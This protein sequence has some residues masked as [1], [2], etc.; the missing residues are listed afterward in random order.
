[1]AMPK[2]R[3]VLLLVCLLLDWSAPSAARAE[4]SE[5]RIAKKYGVGYLTLMLM[6]DRGLVEKQAA[7]AGLGDVKVTWSTFR[8]SD[9]MNDALLSGSVDCVWLGVSGLATIW[10]KTRGNADVRAVSGLKIGRAHV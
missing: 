3:L 1:M 7:A 8:S 2:R 9:T 4:Q 6:E 10:A 5:L